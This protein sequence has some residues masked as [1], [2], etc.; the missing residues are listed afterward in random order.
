VNTADLASAGV[1]VAS[2]INANASVNFAMGW[3]LRNAPYTQKHGAFGDVS[4]SF[5][6]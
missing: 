1:E 2:Q 4:V 3:Q 6:L 5:G